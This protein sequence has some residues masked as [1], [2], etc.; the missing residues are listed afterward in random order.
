M[1]VLCT[2]KFKWTVSILCMWNFVIF[3]WC[4][5]ISYLLYIYIYIICVYCWC[6]FGRGTPVSAWGFL[7]VAFRVDA[8]LRLMMLSRYHMVPGPNLGPLHAKNLLSLL[9][10]LSGAVPNKAEAKFLSHHIDYN[11]LEL[12]NAYFITLHL[13]NLACFRITPMILAT[14]CQLGAW[15]VSPRDARNRTWGSSMQVALNPLSWSWN[16]CF[17][18]NA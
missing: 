12:Y 16:G 7:T 4:V 10:L 18:F 1:K 5:Y 13:I 2:F 6:C 9:G 3:I 17:K 15:G 8:G 14:Y 11:F